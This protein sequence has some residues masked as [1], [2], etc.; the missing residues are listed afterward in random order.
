[1]KKFKKL[2]LVDMILNLFD[3]VFNQTNKTTDTTATTGNDLSVEMKTYYSDYLID[4]AEPELVHDQFGQKRPIPKNG[5]KTIEF[6]KFSKLPKALTPITEGV[7]PAGNKLRASAMTAT[8][9]EVPWPLLNR[10]VQRILAEVKGVNRVLY[11]LSPK[12]CATIEWE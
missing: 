7:T 5:G 9:E 2:I 3:P 11:D 1:M 8:V 12:P 4:M 6:R 10:I